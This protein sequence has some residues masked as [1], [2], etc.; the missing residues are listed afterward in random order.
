MSLSLQPTA[1]DAA[2]TGTFIGN[3]I[4]EDALEVILA[5]RE[6]RHN[7]LLVLRSSLAL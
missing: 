7:P 5:L 3:E 2:V 6:V 1:P 4:R